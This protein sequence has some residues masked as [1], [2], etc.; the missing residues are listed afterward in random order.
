MVS[1]QVVYHTPPPQT[2][3]VQQPQ[4]QVIYHQ[5][6]T[7]V[8]VTQT[9]TVQEEGLKDEDVVCIGCCGALAALLCFAAAG[10]AASKDD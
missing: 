8:M 2:I 5:Q 9:R 6:P 7:P 10:S 4:P 3:Y 1:P